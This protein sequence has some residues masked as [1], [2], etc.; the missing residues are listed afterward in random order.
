MAVLHLIGLFHTIP[1]RKYSHCAFTQK[2]LRFGPMMEDRGYKVI[3]YSN[4]ES[5]SGVEQV[6]ILTEKELEELRTAKSIKDFVG[7]DATIGSDLWAMFNARLI[8]RMRARVEDKDIICYPF[9]DCHPD[10]RVLFPSCPHVETGIGYPDTFSQFRVFESSAWMHYH[11]GKE[12]AVN[13]RNYNWVVPNYYD[14]GDWDMK[15]EKGKYILYFG[16][17][18]PTKGLETIMEIGKRLEKLA[19][20]VPRRLIICGQGDPTSYLERCPSIEYKEPIHGRD[21]SDLLGNAYCVLMPTMFIEP[22]GGSGVEAQLC[23]TPLI[24][25]NYGAFQETVV[26]GVTGFRCNT[27]G[28]WLRAIE[29]VG[30]LNRETI[31]SMARKKYS[32]ETCGKLYDQIFK[33]IIDLGDKGWYSEHSNR[34]E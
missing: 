23:G 26:D 28:D 33:D 16:R 14:L 29:R 25:I 15:T 13:G 32:L 10:L 4:G 22:F 9:G 8:E 18:A 2:Q 24:G 3:E 21:R 11:Y 6:Q 27:L 34:I 30:D 12:K 17:I 7:N 1:S 5:E 20:H 31:A 19:P